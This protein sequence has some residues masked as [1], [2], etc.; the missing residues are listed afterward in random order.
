[1]SI[2]IIGLAI[3]WGS[4]TPRKF[5]KIKI[6]V[7]L[8]QAVLVLGVL[9][10]VSFVIPIE[11]S[12]REL[13]QKGKRIA[14]YDVGKELAIYCQTLKRDMNDG[15]I[16]TAWLPRAVAEVNPSWV[17][18]RPNDAYIALGGGFFPLGASLELDAEA[19]TDEQ[20]V[21]QYSYG[22]AD[23]SGGEKRIA[24][25]ELN[26]S[27]VMPLE[28]LLQKAIAGYDRQIAKQPTKC[29][30]HK[31]KIMFLLKFDLDDKAAQA[32][33]YAVDSIPDDAMLQVLLACILS[34]KPENVSA[35]A[36]QF[37][38]WTDIHANFPNYDA[39]V[40]NRCGRKS[41]VSCCDYWN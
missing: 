33:R 19:S 36:T 25:I 2:A 35:A 4:M 15:N 11:M 32:C 20:T 21:W 28:E 7:L 18:L 8:F 39:C 38:Q 29:F 1:M 13:E 5:K 9:L 31:A 24:T 3:I 22:L 16:G 41:A 26:Q 30:S 6:I 14:T 12:Q 23:A 40:K 37:E 17:S 27:D 34:G 10:F